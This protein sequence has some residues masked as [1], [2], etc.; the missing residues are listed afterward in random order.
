MT[1]LEDL[2]LVTGRGRYAASVSFPHQ[3]H[4][5]VVRSSHGHGRIVSIDVSAARAAKGCAGVWTFADVADIP[6]IEFRPTKIEG[7]EAYRQ[8]VLAENRVRYVGEPVAV[9]FANDSYLAEDIADLVNVEIEPLPVITSASQVPG[10]FE[11]GRNTEPTVIRK[12]FGDLEGAFRAAHAV[13][14]LDLTIGR[15]SGVPME[16]RGAIA[17]YDTTRDVLELHGAT[18]R[19]HPNRDM[20]ARMLRRSPASIHLYECHIGGGF[21]VRGEIYPEDVLVCIATLRL[22]RPVKWIEDRRE[23]LMACNQSREQRHRVRAAIDAEGRILALDDEFFH[24]Q[25]AYVRTHGARVADGTASMLPGPYHVP[26]FRVAGHFRLTNKTP[27][28]T[29]RSP[30]RFESTFVHERLMDAIAA[31]LA[32]DPLDVRRRNLIR[33]AQMPYERAVSVAGAPV[34][35]DSGDYPAHLEKV[36]AR[37]GWNDLQVEMKQRR[38]AGESVGAGIAYFLEKSGQGPVEGVRVSVDTTGAVELVTGAASVGQGMETVL[39]QICGDALGVDYRSVRV[40]HGR[41]DRIDY[42]FGANAARVT[43]MTGSA[44]HIAA[45]KLR[46][47]AL[48]VAASDMLEATADMLDVVD[49]RIVRRDRPGSPSVTLAQ[50]AKE[51]SPAAAVAKGRE[52]GLTAEGVFECKEEAF[53]YGAHV[54]VVKVDRETGGVK[55]ERYLASYDIGVAVNPMLVEGQIVGSAVQGLGGA[56][57]EEFVYDE[58]GTPLAVTFAD[59]ML[60]TMQDVPDI[61]V[62]LTQDSPSPLNPL[63]LKGGG[64]SGITACGAVIASAIEDALGMP[65]IITQLPVTPQRLERLLREHGQRKDDARSHAIAIE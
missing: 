16:T 45:T 61:D 11:P 21:G 42:G 15:H 9:V 12:K 10:E 40:V 56:L 4:M 39:A 20:L 46:A 49:G 55:I 44:T 57:F 23:N 54:A 8:R 27:A 65:G 52:P 19:P 24:D 29:Y 43:I 25:G 60:P 51:L 31:R 3:L 1:R 7:L 58:N 36:L 38:R 17:R 32:I 28:A 30:G 26:A 62:M 50:V 35:L 18:K 34:T 53:P 33:G 14:E 13:I 37:I 47:K 64:E 41:T 6:P 48:E 59:Y 63:G 22:G 5:R 2:P